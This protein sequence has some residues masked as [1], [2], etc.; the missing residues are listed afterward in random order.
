MKLIFREPHFSVPV[1]NR[2]PSLQNDSVSLGLRM[3]ATRPL[4]GKH[5]LAVFIDFENL[6]HGLAGRR[7]RFAIDKVFER[8]VERG[9]IVVKKAYCDWNRFVPFTGPLHEAAVELIEI[10]KRTL[11]GKNSADIRLVVDAIDLAYSKDHID[12]FVILSGDSDFS[13]LVS[14]LKEL[15]KYVMGVGL[16]NATSELLRDNCDEFIYYEDIETKPMSAPALSDAIPEPKRK[17]YALLLE[18]LLALRREN[19]GVLNASM[20]KDTMKRKKPSFNEEYFGFRTFSDLLQ[21]ARTFGVIDLARGKTSGTLY[22]TKFKGELTKANGSKEVV[23]DVTDSTMKKKRRRKK[24]KVVSAAVNPT[25]ASALP[26]NPLT[27]PVSKP[28]SSAIASPFDDDEV[29]LGFPSYRPHQRLAEPIS[30]KIPQVSLPVRP[31]QAPEPPPSP[32]PLPPPPKRDLPVRPQPAPE[33]PPLPR[34]L[35]PPPKRDLKPRKL[36]DEDFGAGLE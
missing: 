7:D 19:Q 16:A 3:A 34:P 13:P 32:R 15:G 23:D 11:T 10:P 31:R 4:D 20:V 18:S 5:T 1:G 27:V 12:T 6:A 21:E 2:G 29:P 26:P 36:N 17:M 33:P 35:P 8:L 28:P 24:K 30:G 22:V 25:T 14:K 9:K